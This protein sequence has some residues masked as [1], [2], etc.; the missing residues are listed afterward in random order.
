MSANK[1]E[2]RTLFLTNRLIR[3]ATALGRITA[4]VHRD[5]HGLT[6]PEFSVLIILGAA[7][8]K[9][10]TSSYIVE[11]TAMDKTKVSRAVSS[12]D[13]RGWLG[14]SRATADRRFEYLTLTEAGRR[15]YL[16]LV[17]KVE[18][19]ENQVLSELSEDELAGLERGLAGL[20]RALDQE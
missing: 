8:G 9:A 7:D 2:G 18:E 15:A 17:P 13:R 19:A 5:E 14:R 3:A 4:Q 20:D 11:T 10:F 16:S 1:T 12:L 6:A